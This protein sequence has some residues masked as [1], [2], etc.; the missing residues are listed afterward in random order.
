MPERPPASFLFLAG[1]ALESD[2]GRWSFD[3]AP[4]KDIPRDR[5]G[6]HLRFRQGRSSRPKYTANLSPAPIAIGL[7]GSVHALLPLST[8]T[9]APSAFA[10]RSNV[11]G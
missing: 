7:C 5:A 8:V 1:V 11:P 2:S 3:T 9:V 10:N 4:R 6:N